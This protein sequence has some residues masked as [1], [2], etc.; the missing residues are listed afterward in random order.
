VT[1]LGV[2]REPD[3]ICGSYEALHKTVSQVAFSTCPGMKLEHGRLPTTRTGKARRAAKDL[4]PV[5]GQSLDVLWVPG[6]REGVV[7][8]RVVQATLMVSGGE[9]QKGGLAAG[10]LEH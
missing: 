5:A 6:V 3:V 4:G 1:E 8:D 2:I 9:G 10:K 7:Q